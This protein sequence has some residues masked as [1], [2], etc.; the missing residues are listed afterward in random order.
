MTG[1][2]TCALPISNDVV[3]VV[4]SDTLTGYDI[5]VVDAVAN[6]T[7]LTLKSNTSFSGPAKLEKVT[8]PN[9]AFKYNRDD[10]VITYIDK[11]KGIHSTYKTFAIKVVLVSSSTL[12]VPIMRDI[13]AL[14]VSI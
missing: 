1:V 11:T 4:Q 6:N 13:R 3:K 7:S 14:A 9:A 2:Q 5:A 10:N 8:Q 12:Y